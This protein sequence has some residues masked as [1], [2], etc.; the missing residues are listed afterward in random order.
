MKK[1]PYCAEEI[2]NDAKKC[3]HCGEWLSVSEEIKSGEKKQEII[4]N[5][6]PPK[7]NSI[8]NKY[9][10]F[11]KNIFSGRVGRG[12]FFAG[13]LLCMVAFV[14][15]FFIF[16]GVIEGISSNLNDNI[17]DA[18]LIFLFAV[19]F[20]LVF[21][22]WLIWLALAVRRLHD[23]GYSGFVIL[24]GFVPLLNIIIGWALLLYPGKKIANGYGDVPNEKRNLLKRVLNL[25]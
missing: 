13:W 8:I 10:Y 18:T 1:C 6:L 12:D 19:T 15:I 24:L 7:K 16:A 4:K 9:L 14:L 17:I 20:L 2:Q 11:I 22:V 3:K 21:H 23:F 25:V 5:V